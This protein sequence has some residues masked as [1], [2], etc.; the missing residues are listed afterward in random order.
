MSSAKGTRQELEA[1]LEEK[2]VNALFIKI[3]ESF[4]VIKPEDPIQHII[5]YLQTH[6]PEQVAKVLFRANRKLKLNNNK[7]PSRQSSL[8]NGTPNDNL[9]PSDSEEET[10]EKE[11]E[12]EEEDEVNELRILHVNT[13]QRERRRSVSAES[14]DPKEAKSYLKVVHQKT[15][16]ERQRINDIIKNNVL[17]KELDANQME[18]MLDAIFPRAYEAGSVI[19]KQGDEGDNFYVLDSGVCEIHKDGKLVATCTESMSFGELALMYNAPRAATVTAK[20]KVKVWTLDR[21]TFKVVLMDTTTKRSDEHE[22]LIKRVPILQNL[23]YYERL[24]AVDALQPVY[25]SHGELIIREG[26]VGDY[27]YI[28][29]EGQ[30]TCY[31]QTERDKPPVLVTTLQPG[32]YFGEIALLTKHPRQATIYAKGENVK[33]LRLD[34]KTFKRVMG[35]LEDILKRN[36]DVYMAIMANKQEENASFVFDI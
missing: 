7:E 11:E 2:G 12:E 6:Y 36:M 26:D 9:G 21:Q 1:Y 14:I 18:I 31:K 13:A 27:F 23:N 30:A 4:S 33:C 22:H 19:I 3:A 28:L 5:E 29:E 24:V 17:F 20:E 8:L 32:A 16:H 15:D 25:Y 34:R 10:S 35:P